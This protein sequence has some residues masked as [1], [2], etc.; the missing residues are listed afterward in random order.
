MAYWLIKSEPDAF[1]IDD[2]KAVKSEIWD[3]IRNYQARNYL[4]SASVGDLAFFYHSNAKPPG[5]VGLAKFV[6][7][8][9][10]DPSQFDPTSK[11]FDPT[12]K[13][14]APRWHTVS[15]KFVEKFRAELSLDTLK[16]TFSGDELMVVR[17]GMRLSVT[18][19]ADDVAGRILGMAGSKHAPA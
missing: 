3:G 14:D 8:G 9:V 18:P 17:R 15:V 10:V 11:Y 2:L 19:V 4:M 6:K 5:I 7:V 16:E 12:S 1:S 13:P